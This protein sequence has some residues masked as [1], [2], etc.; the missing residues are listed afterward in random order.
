MTTTW[1]YSLDDADEATSVLIGVERQRPYFAS[2]ESNRNYSM[3]NI[4]ETYR[5]IVTV[6]SEIA[7]ARMLGLTDFVPH[8]NKWRSEPDVAIFEVR[9]AFPSNSYG[10]SLRLNDRD[11][12]TTPYVLLTEGSAIR[13]KRN[14]AEGGFNPSHPYKALG[15]CYPSEVKFEHYKEH[16]GGWRIPAYA[17]RPMS[18]LDSTV[19][20]WTAQSVL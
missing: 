3:G 4:D 8:V 9:Y 20:N 2:P 7:F 10:P 12:D 13:T 17:L 14:N 16:F 19:G 1:E 18:E 15:W 6:G 11:K 5:H